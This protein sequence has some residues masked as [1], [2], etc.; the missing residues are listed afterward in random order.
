MTVEY[1]ELKERLTIRQA[2]EI[3]RKELEDY[4]TINTCYVVDNERKL[5]G[6]VNLKHIICANENDLIKDIVQRDIIS[7]QTMLDQEETAMMFQKYDLTA[8]P[9]VDSENRLVGIITIDD[10]VDVLQEENTEDIEKMAAITPTHKSY[11][12]DFGCWMFSN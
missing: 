5:I 4:E 3:L 2:I 8:M 1:A 9:V 11:Y 10:I 7:C 6:Y 12:K